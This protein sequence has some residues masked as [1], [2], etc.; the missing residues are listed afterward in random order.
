MKLRNRSYWSRFIKNL[1]GF[2]SI[3]SVIGGIVG[4]VYGLGYLIIWNTVLGAAVTGMVLIVATAAIYTWNETTDKFELV[5]HLDI[6]EM[7]SNHE[8]IVEEIKESETK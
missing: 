3:I 8:H 4:I 7:E 6:E 1:F 2:M 5:P